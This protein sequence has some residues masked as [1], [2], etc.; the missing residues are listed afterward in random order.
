MIVCVSL[1]SPSHRV[2]SIIEN[3]KTFNNKRKSFPTFNICCPVVVKTPKFHT[4]NHTHSQKGTTQFASIAR[5]VFENICK[6]H[7][8]INIILYLATK[9]N[10]MT[11]H[12][13]EKNHLFQGCTFISYIWWWYILSIYL[14]QYENYKLQPSLEACV[15]IFFVNA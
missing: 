11:R 4:N 14:L 15:D 12:V 10:E 3:N 2:F 6:G 7:S 13:P 5:K 8:F 9:T 1:P